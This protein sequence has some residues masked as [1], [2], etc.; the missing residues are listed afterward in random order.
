MKKD[1]DTLFCRRCRKGY[2]VIDKQ[3]EL[4]NKH[5]ITNGSVESITCFSQ[6]I[7]FEEVSQTLKKLIGIE[8]STTQMCI[9]LE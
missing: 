2:G 6:F 3:L 7:P 8:V 5:R 9:I 1:I 4:Y